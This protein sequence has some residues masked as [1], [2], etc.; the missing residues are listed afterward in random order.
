LTQQVFV[1]TVCFKCILEKYKNS[2]HFFLGLDPG[3]CVIVYLR[4]QYVKFEYAIKSIKFFNQ[5]SGNHG[6]KKKTDDWK[7]KAKLVEIE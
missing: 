3:L 5:A 7:D 1:D 2:T 4:N 6:K